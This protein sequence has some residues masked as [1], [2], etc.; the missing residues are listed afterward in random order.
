MQVAGRMLGAQDGTQQ[1]LLLLADPN[2]D[3]SNVISGASQ[4]EA[5]LK[6]LNQPQAVKVDKAIVAEQTRFYNGP[7]DV[8]AATIEL[9]KQINQTY[10]DD[11]GICKKHWS[12]RQIAHCTSSHTLRPVTIVMTQLLTKHRLRASCKETRLAV[13]LIGVH[14]VAATAAA[15][16]DSALK[17]VSVCSHNSV[18]R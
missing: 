2:G 1:H 18:T 16:C 17:Y 8:D 15:T 4:A 12:I 3:S 10:W 14:C 7:M 9:A 6:E 13:T 5:H 11:P